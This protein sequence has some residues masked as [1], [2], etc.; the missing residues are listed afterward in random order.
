MLKLP[1][2]TAARD[3]CVLE[4]VVSPMTLERLEAFLEFLRVCKGGAHQTISHFSEWLDGQENGVCGRCTQH[5]GK[6]CS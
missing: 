6:R 3:A 1:P 2:E 4:H 5:G